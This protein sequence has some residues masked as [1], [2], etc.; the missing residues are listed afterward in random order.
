MYESLIQHTSDFHLYIFA[1]DDTAYNVLIKLA[2]PN[3]TVIP[4]NEF[5]DSELLKVKPTRSIA[6]YCWTCTPSTILYCIQKYGLDNCTYIDADLFFYSDPKVLI[7]EMGANSVLITAHRYTPEYDQTAES[8]KYCVQFTTFRNDEKGMK[9]LNWWRYECLKWCYA[10][11]EDG[12]FGD[13][14]YLDDWTTRFEGVHELAHIGGGVAPWNLQQYDFSK[15]NNTIFLREEGKERNVALVFF[16][17]HHLKFY[18]NDIVKITSN[19]LISERVIRY[20][21]SPYIRQLVEMK[22]RIKF[23]TPNTDPGGAKSNSPGKPYSLR[24]KIHLYK[25]AAMKF[26]YREIRGVAQKINLH[27]FFYLNDIL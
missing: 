22:R 21:Y 6:E 1:F 7:D 5:E 12:K 26:N 16:H 27:N 8:G 20:L 9:V 2:L 24:D 19:Y 11:C 15:K 25:G 14:K 10:K 13:Q 4:L 17:F 23:L 18:L 3:I